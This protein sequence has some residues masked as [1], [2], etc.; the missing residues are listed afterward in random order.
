MCIIPSDGGPWRP[1]GPRGPRAVQTADPW[2]NVNIMLA[3]LISPDW[4]LTTGGG[5][6]DPTSSSPPLLH[7]SLDPRFTSTFPR[8][9]SLP[10]SFLFFLSSLA[11]ID[12]INNLLQVKMRKRYSVDKTLSHPW[13]QVS[14][15][16]K[17]NIY[18][19]SFWGYFWIY[20]K[21]KLGWKRKTNIG[22]DMK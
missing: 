11:A 10:F 3:L 15:L 19:Q 7:P 12:L 5:G 1:E 9:S 18:I 16:I 21:V 14:T 20:L 8:S 2:R 6:P 17:S 13:L 22:R 4:P